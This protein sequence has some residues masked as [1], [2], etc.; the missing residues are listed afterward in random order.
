M[1]LCQSL[2]PGA[3]NM[4][5]TRNVIL[6]GALRLLSVASAV[7]P[8]SAE[9]F[10]SFVPDFAATDFAVDVDGFGT[11]DPDTSVAPV[12]RVGESVRYVFLTSGFVGTTG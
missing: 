2:H 11:R 3:L 10:A 12:L 8:L 4:L 5:F 6:F 7:R 1:L 9:A